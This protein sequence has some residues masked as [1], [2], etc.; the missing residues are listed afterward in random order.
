MAVMVRKKR[1]WEAVLTSEKRT[2]NPDAKT[3]PSDTRV[4]AKPGSDTTVPATARVTISR[5]ANPTV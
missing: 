5:A 1:K 3:N 4:E 2:R